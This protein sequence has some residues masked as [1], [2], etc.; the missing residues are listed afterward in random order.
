M[1]KLINMAEKPLPQNHPQIKG[2][3]PPLFAQLTQIRQVIHLPF[4]LQ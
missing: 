4:P 1:N 2:E 3:I